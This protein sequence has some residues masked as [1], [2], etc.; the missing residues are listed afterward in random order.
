LAV[1]DQFWTGIDEIQST[2]DNEDDNWYS[3]DGRRI[4][5]RQLKRGIYIKNGKKILF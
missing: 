1:F 5:K 2:I 3:L 4:E